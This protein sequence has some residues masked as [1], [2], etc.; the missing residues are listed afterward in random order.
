MDA[1]MSRAEMLDQADRIKSAGDRL[2]EA[3]EN[4]RAAAAILNLVRQHGDERPGMPPVRRRDGS[5]TRFAQIETFLAE[6]GPSTRQE[7]VA[8][9]GVPEGTVR[10]LLI[11]RYFDEDA[12]GRWSARR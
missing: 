4:L 8:K 3:A 10:A 2:H 1:V 12:E 5:P 11:P 6:H 9:S 7:I